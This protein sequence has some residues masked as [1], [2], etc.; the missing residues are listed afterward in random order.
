VC[1][2]VG[3]GWIPQAKL[4]AEA[5]EAAAKQ[6]EAAYQA[7][8]LQMQTEEAELAKAQQLQQLRTRAEPVRK[9]I[10]EAVM[11]HLTEA[12]LAVVQ[13]RVPSPYLRARKPAVTFVVS[14]RRHP[15]PPGGGVPAYETIVCPVS[16]VSVSSARDGAG[17]PG[18]MSSASKKPRLGNSM[19][20]GSASTWEL[21]C[22]GGIVAWGDRLCVSAPAGR[23]RGVPGH[24]A[25]AKSGG[26]GGGTQA[27]ADLRL[28]LGCMS[29]LVA[30]QL[31][32]SAYGLPSSPYIRPSGYLRRGAPAVLL[33]GD[34]AVPTGRWEL[35]ATTGWDGHAASTTRAFSSACTALS[36]ASWLWGWLWQI[37]FG[38]P[39]SRG[40]SKA[41]HA[42]RLEKERRKTSRTTTFDLPD[43]EEGDEGEAAEAAAVEADASK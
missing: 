30:G 3:G 33:D 4:A 8:L 19:C 26:G 27:G 1:V 25:G 5:A 18:W 11:P 9:A 39:N 37:R 29:E 20:V 23:P 13:V 10:M 43:D 31:Q 21:N 15:P 22:D 16:D 36:P 38:R 34:Q 12:M 17:C 7:R 35:L 14:H 6:Q 32:G 41:R 2:G 24:A 42:E 28:R 40:D